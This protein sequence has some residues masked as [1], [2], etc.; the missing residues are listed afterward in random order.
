MS[1]TRFTPM[2]MYKS[3]WVLRT[4]SKN[5]RNRLSIL[6][7]VAPTGPH[8]RMNTQFIN[9]LL[10]APASMVSSERVLRLYTM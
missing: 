10:M 3:E 9:K 6:A 4:R 8:T 7:A 5:T 1:A 2:V